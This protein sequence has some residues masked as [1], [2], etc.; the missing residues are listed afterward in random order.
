[1]K[2][3]VRIETRSVGDA[4]GCCGIVRDAK[5]G[6]KL[7]ETD[8]Y[9]NGCEQSARSAA[10]RIAQ[11]RGYEID[12]ATDWNAATN[13]DRIRK[14]HTI[15]LSAEAHAKLEELAK[16]HGSISGA[17]EALALAAP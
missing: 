17:I 13:K 1:M 11:E 8:T 5:S 3:K 15:T 10:K 2:R 4:F 12:P 14:M 6:R 7:A 16:V 9:P